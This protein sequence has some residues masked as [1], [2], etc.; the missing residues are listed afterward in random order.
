MELDRLAVPE[1]RLGLSSEGAGGEDRGCSPISPYYFIGSS[2]C[3]ALL[4][5][6]QFRLSAPEAFV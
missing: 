2:G 6:R 1:P 4:L 3:Q 5:Y